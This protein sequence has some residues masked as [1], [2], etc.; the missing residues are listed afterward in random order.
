MRL[1]TLSRARWLDRRRRRRW[2]S[3]LAARVGLGVIYP[4]VGA[5]R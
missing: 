4:R 3:V 1:P 2:A 5:H